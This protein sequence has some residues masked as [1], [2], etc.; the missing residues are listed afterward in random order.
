[1]RLLLYLLFIPIFLLHW[2]G[3]LL[4]E[5]FF[6]GYRK[7]EITQPVFVL[8]VPRSGTT[9]LHRTLAADQQLF[10]TV[11]TWEVFLAPSI[12]QR[13]F[14][15]TLAHAD[16][17]IGRPFARLVA[18]L[19]K[20]LFKGLEGIH[21][22]SLQAAEEDYLLLLPLMSCFIL[23]LP[24]TES[25]YIW[26]LSRLDWDM[27][28]TDRQRIMNFYKACLQ[29]HLYFHGK[30]KRF[31]SK[32]AAFASWVISLREYF[33]DA[34]FVICLREPEKAVPSLIGSLES[35]AQFFELN[36]TDGSLPDQL[37]EMMQDYYRHLIT[38]HRPEWEVVQMHELQTGINQRIGTIYQRFGLTLSDEYR[39]QLET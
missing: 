12:T 25:S 6:R 2:L 9:F 18:Y 4:D 13:V 19:E 29:K 34:H 5:I 35:G 30:N 8:G 10:T 1:M 20:R 22:V 14:W 21:D 24:F 16:K 37:V 28:E 31:L 32:N 11:S 15:R 3:F 23:F 7:V 33:P 26:N 39:Q 38:N 27:P 17:M 36:L